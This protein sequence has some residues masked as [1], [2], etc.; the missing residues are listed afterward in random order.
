MKGLVHESAPTEN[1]P[2]PGARIEIQGEVGGGAIPTTDG[3]GRFTLEVEA[4]SVTLIVS[5]DGYDSKSV[6]ISAL[7][8]EIQPDIGLVPNGPPVRSA[9][10]GALCTVATW[11]V[12]QSPVPCWGTNYPYPLE[13]YHQFPVHR[14]G[15]TTIT[16]RYR[17]VGDYDWNY[18]SFQL[19]CSGHVV[20]E[21]LI[22]NLWNSHPGN[23][24]P[25]QVALSQPCLYQAR[26]FD[27]FA[28]RKG[29]HWTTYTVDVEHP[30]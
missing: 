2:V 24:G 19:L 1:I 17:Y 6:A 4:A 11:W 27:Y 14:S 7:T 9:Y 22:A 3:S 18:L 10:S 13:A 28:D 5:K 12:P 15:I 30:K 29:G 25:F 23:T 8:S 20:V 26:L 21:K 16:V